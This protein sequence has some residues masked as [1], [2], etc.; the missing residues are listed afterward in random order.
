[1]AAALVCGMCGWLTGAAICFGAAVWITFRDAGRDDRR[2][3]A[4]L[5]ALDAER[6]P[7]RRLAAAER[8][9]AAR[10]G[11]ARP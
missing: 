7:L 3:R 11:R 8:E 10:H 2:L 6:H 9:V 4:R 1:M 5:D